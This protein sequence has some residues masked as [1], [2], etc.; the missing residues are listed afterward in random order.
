MRRAPGG[1]VTSG[2]ETVVW[3]RRQES[4][5]YLSL[6]RTPFYP[7]NYGEPVALRKA[8]LSTMQHLFAPV[9]VVQCYRRALG[10]LQRWHQ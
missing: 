8:F 9:C 1:G 7:L 10:V 5:L 4:N 2:P 6:R 3:S